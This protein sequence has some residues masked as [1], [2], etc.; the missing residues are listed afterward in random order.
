[1]PRNGRKGKKNFN[2]FS[3][4]DLRIKLFLTLRSGDFI[5][6]VLLCVA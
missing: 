1:M 6:L 4:I 2:L 5:Q 3:E